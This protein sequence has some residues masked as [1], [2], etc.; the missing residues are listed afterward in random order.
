M[1]I[2]TFVHT[3]LTILYLLKR[4]LQLYNHSSDVALEMAWPAWWP[5]PH[6]N[7]ALTRLPVPWEDSEPAQQWGRRQR[8]GVGGTTL[9][10]FADVAGSPD[11]QGSKLSYTAVLFK[12]ICD[13]VEFKSRSRN[14][15]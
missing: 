6:I 8:Y 4:V 2:S 7:A 1:Y 10:R 5:L 3:Q 12:N 9:S 14:V 11:W 15:Q 13:I